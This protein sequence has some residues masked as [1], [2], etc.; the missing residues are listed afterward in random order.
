MGVLG[1][2]LGTIAGGL[3]E[4]FF[5]IKGVNGAQV[6]G[7]LGSL[8]PFKNGG[9]VPGRRGRPKVILAHSGETVLPLGCPATKAQKAFIAKKKRAAKKK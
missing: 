1:G 2:L 4:K 7:G 8:L 9:V 6:G 5:P 3:G